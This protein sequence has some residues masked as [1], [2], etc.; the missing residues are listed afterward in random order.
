MDETSTHDLAVSGPWADAHGVAISAR[1]GQA[2]EAERDERR[3][4][5]EGHEQRITD[6]QAQHTAHIKRLH[7]EVEAAQQHS[8]AVKLR[9][10]EMQA[11]AAV[12]TALQSPLWL[13]Y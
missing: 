6:L 12:G 10:D 4:G 2:L 11:S 9:A 5:A 3:K 1:A 13:Q 7:A 8:A